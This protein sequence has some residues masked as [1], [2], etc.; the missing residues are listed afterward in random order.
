M[1]G[2][3]SLDVIIAVTVLMLL[4]AW[5][6]SFGTMN[7]GKIDKFGAQLNVKSA[8]IDVG[9][10][11]NSFYAWKPGAN[12]YIIISKSLRFFNETYVLSISKPMNALNVSVGSLHQ[13][14]PYNSTYPVASLLKY[15]A[16]TKKVTQ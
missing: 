7:L 3:I 13:F 12:D 2:L 1:K 16:T 9:S 8:A 11:M 4:F 10:R 14:F 15:D 6:Q 5:L